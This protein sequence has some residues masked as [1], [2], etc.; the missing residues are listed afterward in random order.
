MLP[1]LL[2][3]V[4]RARLDAVAWSI[5]KHPN[6]GPYQPLTDDAYSRLVAHLADSL[7]AI[8]ITET[9]TTKEI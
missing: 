3:S 9:T 5:G 1:E 4:C 7:G 6:C 8:D 2:C